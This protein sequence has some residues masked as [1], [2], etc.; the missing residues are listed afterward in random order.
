VVKAAIFADDNDDVLDRLA[1]LM[2]SSASSARTPGEQASA[3]R[4]TPSR[5]NLCA[6]A[7]FDIATSS[8][9]SGK[10]QRARFYSATMTRIFRLRDRPKLSQHEI[11]I[12]RLTGGM[13]FAQ[14]KRRSRS[15]RFELDWRSI[16]RTPMPSCRSVGVP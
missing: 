9:I 5:P 2:G 14:S 12:A 8:W 11:A 1:V 7:V 6:S 10:R 13:M 4:E 16:V 15:H 3:A